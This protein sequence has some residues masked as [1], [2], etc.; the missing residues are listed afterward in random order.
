MNIFARANLIFLSG[1]TAGHESPSD[2]SGAQNGSLLSYL[3]ELLWFFDQNLKRGLTSKPLV[4]KFN[5][6]LK[7]RLFTIFDEEV[8]KFF[9]SANS[10]YQRNRDPAVFGDL[11][12]S[13]E[14]SMAFRHN[15]SVKLQT[16]QLLNIRRKL[17]IQGSNTLTLISNYLTAVGDWKKDLEAMPG[18]SVGEVTFSAGLKGTDLFVHLMSVSS[19]RPRQGREDVNFRIQV[20][21]LPLKVDE[22]NYKLSQRTLIYSHK[23]FHLVSQAL[24]NIH[25]LPPPKISKDFEV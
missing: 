14:E 16:E 6:R 15:V 10:Q 8:A 11:E 19:L 23:T 25:H 18:L 9:E 4:D 5:K 17:T 12:N 13:I 1:S 7:Q 22:K 3:D 2:P 24:S 20:S 21:V